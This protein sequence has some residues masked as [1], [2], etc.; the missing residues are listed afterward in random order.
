MHI[1]IYVYT[2]IH[3]WQCPINKSAALN[4]AT[5]GKKVPL[6]TPTLHQNVQDMYS[7]AEQR[8]FRML[9][10]FFRGC[11]FLQ[12][13][14]PSNQSRRLGVHPGH[15][16]AQGYIYGLAWGFVSHDNIV[17]SFAPQPLA[18]RISL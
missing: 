2:Y 1:H 7:R 10:T 13:C 14:R 16:W 11:S 5:R 12:S 3:I 8:G 15:W 18:L 17:Y 9:P 4:R 6:A